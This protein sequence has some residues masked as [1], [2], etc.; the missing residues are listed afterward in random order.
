MDEYLSVSFMV[1][2][3]NWMDSMGAASRQSWIPGSE[4]TGQTC[5]EANGG[6]LHLFMMR[7]QTSWS[8]SLVLA[9]SWQTWSILHAQ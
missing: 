7:K 4:A 3:Y 8:S 2:K 9:S 1:V 5:I 6:K